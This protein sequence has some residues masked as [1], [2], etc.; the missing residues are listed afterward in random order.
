MR[1]EYRQIIHL[2][3]REPGSPPLARGVLRPVKVRVL[4]PGI[5]PACAG[6]TLCYEYRKIWH[7]DHPRLRGE[8]VVRTPRETPYLGSPPLA[9]GVLTSRGYACSYAR[10]TPACAGSTILQCRKKQSMK[11]HPRLRGEYQAE[12]R[13]KQYGYGSPPLARGVH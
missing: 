11:D 13:V 3:V 9:R 12:A 5:T 8:Y 2:R 10:I 7:Q 1:G 4:I 6:S